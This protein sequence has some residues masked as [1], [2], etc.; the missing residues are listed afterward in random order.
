MRYIYTIVVF[1]LFVVPFCFA[2]DEAKL[3]DAIQKGD[4][5]T[6]AEEALKL[7]RSLA[8]KKREREALAFFQQSASIA[9]EINDIALRARANEEL[10]DAYYRTNDPSKAI[11]SLNTAAKYYSSLGAAQA[12]TQVINRI[13][14][15]EKNKNKDFDAAVKMFKKSL[16]IAQQNNLFST[17]LQSYELLATSYQEKG[18]EVNAKFYT[19]LSD[20]LKNTPSKNT[21][22][23]YANYETQIKETEAKLQ[24]TIEL[25]EGEKRQLQTQLKGLENQKKALDK[26][27]SAQADSLVQANYE[28]GMAETRAMAEEEGRKAVQTLLYFS[29]GGIAL[30]VVFSTFLFSLFRSRNIANKRLAEQN[31]QIQK[32]ANELEIKGKDLQKE[33]EKSEKLLLNIL[34]AKIAEELKEKNYAAP[35]YYEKVTVLFTDF[36]GF[37]TIAEKMTPE[38]IIGELNT[39]FSEF[40]RI[41]KEYNLEKIKTIGDAYMCAGGIPEPNTTNATDAVY[42]ALEMQQYMGTLAE[43][44]KAR[45]EHYFELRLGINTGAIVAGVVG[46]SKFAYDIWGDAVNLASR[47]ESG[48]EP[49]RVNISENTYEIIKDNFDCSYRGKITVKNK[50]EVDMYFVNHKKWW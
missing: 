44:K 7:G 32:Q 50:G 5:K 29:Y 24:T 49:G 9:N 28:V 1:L 45:G 48:G 3:N 47:M 14:F 26:I 12:Q 23:S 38:E 17:Q 2:Q 13:G 6:A 19:E 42:A 10:G 4:K 21:V 43:K 46:E 22:E 8:L 37:T 15:T 36:K 30:L 33:K 18:D 25:K 20:K 31:I 27:L 34:P 40:D 11:K 16:Q 39:I 35:R 41:C